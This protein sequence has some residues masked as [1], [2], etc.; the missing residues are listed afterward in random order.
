MNQSTPFYKMTEFWI[1]MLDAAI[2]IVMLILV[3]YAPGQV[4]ELVQQIIIWIQPI[5]V[6]IIVSLLGARAA[7]AMRN[8]AI[9]VLSK[10]AGK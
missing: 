10:I 4:V 6:M 1:A 3:E 7:A 5:I 9:D 2:N 8:I